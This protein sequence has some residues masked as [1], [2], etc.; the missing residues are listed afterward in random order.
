M[1]VLHDGRVLAVGG[2]NREDPIG[3]EVYDPIMNSWIA[4]GDAHTNRLGHVAT[5][6]DDGRV[7]VTGG[8]IQTLD[9][10]QQPTWALFD[11]TSASW[12][13]GNELPWR[14]YHAAVALSG[15]QVV[16]LGGD[17]G[18]MDGRLAD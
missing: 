1:T 4:V 16:V 14:Q 5:L 12:T 11:P 8:E 13:T 10:T 3:A 6:L 2:A 7:L 15:G 9:P 17:R 18:Y